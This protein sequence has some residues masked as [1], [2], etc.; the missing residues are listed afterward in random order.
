MLLLLPF[1]SL[2]WRSLLSPFCFGRLFV[3]IARATPFFYYITS[4]VSRRI[5]FNLLMYAATIYVNI[6]SVSQLNCCNWF[7]KIMRR[8]I[9]PGNLGDSNGRLDCCV[10]MCVCVIQ[11]N[12][13]MQFAN[14]LFTFGWA[15]GLVL[16][17]I[18]KTH[19]FLFS[20]LNF[21][22]VW[23]NLTICNNFLFPFNQKISAEV[24]ARCLQKFEWWSQW[25][26]EWWSSRP[27]HRYRWG[28]KLHHRCG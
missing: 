10:C 13:A 22:F 2:A 1:R 16:T 27:K 7:R 15:L 17:F 14:D 5:S 28:R 11:F 9:F 6:K 21:I 8:A 24:F 25:K 23:I 20:I 19:R 12:H 3:S 4:I 18:L 26:S